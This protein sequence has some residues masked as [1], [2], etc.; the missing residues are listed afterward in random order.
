MKSIASQENI[1][2]SFIGHFGGKSNRFHARARVEVRAADAPR[3]ENALREILAVACVHDPRALRWSDIDGA[4]ERFA[5]QR[6]FEFALREMRAG[7][8]RV[9]VE[10]WDMRSARGGRRRAAPDNS[11]SVVEE[12]A[13]LDSEAPAGGNRA[14]WPDD[15]LFAGIAGLFAGLVSFSYEK[16]DEY[17]AWLRRSGPQC[18][19]YSNEVAEFLPSKVSVERFQVLRHFLE[20]CAVN[21]IGVSMTGARGL[22]T[23]SERARQPDVEQ[24]SADAPQPDPELSTALAPLRISFKVD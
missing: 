20:L 19:L 5:A 9:A 18:A 13:S 10:V 17:T 2:H 22:A 4:K 14:R 6:L 12:E 3:L 23:S 7:A 1:F 16:R 24:L 8:L 11:E 21:E 15:T